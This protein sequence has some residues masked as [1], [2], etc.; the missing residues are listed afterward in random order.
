MMEGTITTGTVT[1]TDL[2][3]VR[4]G[5]KVDHR[6]PKIKIDSKVDNKR[7]H[8]TRRMTLARFKQQVAAVFNVPADKQCLV[9]DKTQ[10]ED[11][12]DE[13]RRGAS[14]NEVNWADMKLPLGFLDS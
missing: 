8:A 10:I 2:E 6:S 1:V 7:K 12:V 9:Y 5:I 14:E 4:H 3:S 13:S 11:R